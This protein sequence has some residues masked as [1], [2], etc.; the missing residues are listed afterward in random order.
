MGLPPENPWRLSWT[1]AITILIVAAGVA[2]AWWLLRGPAI[3]VARVTRGTAVEI[4]YATGAV[5]PVRWAKVDAA[6]SRPHR[7]ALPMRGQDRQ[8]RRRTRPPRRQGS[9]ASCTSCRRARNFAARSR[10]PVATAGRGVAT[11]QAYREAPE[12]PAPHPGADLG[13][14]RSG[15]TTTSSSR[16]WTASCCGG[17]RGRRDRRARHDPVPRRAAEAAAGRGRGQRGGH[18]ARQGRPDRA[19]AHRR[20]SRTS[21]SRARCARSRRWAI[22]SPRPTASASRCPTTRRC[23]SA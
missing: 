20:A 12:R 4:V 1:L 23:A 22:P 2:V 8:A 15:S 17:R 18:P 11:S 16:R 7:R 21:R 3:T 10:P 14:G 6:D 5:E 9:A 13:A 19:A